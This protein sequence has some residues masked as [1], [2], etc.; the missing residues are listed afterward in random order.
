MSSSQ[1]ECTFVCVWGGGVM[2]ENEQGQTRREEGSKLRNL[3][4]TYFLNVHLRRLI[5]ME[6]CKNIL[7]F[8]N[9]ERLLKVYKQPTTLSQ[10]RHKQG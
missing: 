10:K 1:N 2:L 3:E 7:K 5:F 4:R 6:H 8:L 9:L